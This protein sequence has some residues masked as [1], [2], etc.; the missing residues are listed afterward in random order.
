[1]KSEDFDQNPGKSDW[2]VL[3]I[4][5]MEKNKTKQGRHLERKMQCN[6]GFW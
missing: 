1:M 4:W 3:F 2:S 6:G 5:R